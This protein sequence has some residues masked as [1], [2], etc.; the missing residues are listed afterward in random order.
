[1]RPFKRDPPPISR[2]EQSGDFYTAYYAVR[3]LGR[4]AA[5]N[6]HS[7][8]HSRYWRVVR[9]VSALGA[10]GGTSSTSDG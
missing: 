9:Q 6:G 10:A 1:M 3:H 4:A 2:E 8:Q 7:G 5:S